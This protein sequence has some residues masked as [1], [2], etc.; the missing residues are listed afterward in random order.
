MFELSVGDPHGVHPTRFERLASDDWQVDGPATGVELLVDTDGRIYFA[1]FSN[2][3]PIFLQGSFQL[4]Y[5]NSTNYLV[6]RCLTIIP[7]YE[8]RARG[9]SFTSSPTHSQ[10][11]HRS[12]AIPNPFKAF[13]SKSAESVALLGQNNNSGTEQESISPTIAT[14]NLGRVRLEEEES[15]GIVISSPEV[16]L[17]GITARYGGMNERIIGLAWSNTDITV[18][19]ISFKYSPRELKALFKG[20]TV[21]EQEGSLTTFPV[22]F[23][24]RGRI[25]GVHFTDDEAFVVL[26][27]STTWDTIHSNAE[28]EMRCRTTSLTTV[29]GASTPIITQHPL[30]LE[31]R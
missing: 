24:S 25:Q 30:L 12:L 17:E 11:D 15:L 2:I 28:L 26:S 13:G 27:V 22:P 31:P 7:T 8:I 14:S 5:I 16:L 29:C 23:R 21:G 20:F 4:V 3:H 19:Q 1:A 9:R 6:T 10:E 18:N